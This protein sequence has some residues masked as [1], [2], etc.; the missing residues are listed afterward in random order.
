MYAW[1]RGS[2]A[3]RDRGASQVASRPLHFDIM[4]RIQLFDSHLLLKAPR[5]AW[6]SLT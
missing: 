6:T 1:K 4:Q 3:T 5:A 2:H